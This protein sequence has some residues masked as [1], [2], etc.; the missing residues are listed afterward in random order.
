MTTVNDIQH[1]G[2]HYRSDYQHWDLVL[3]MNVPYLE[4]CATKYICRHRKKNGGQDL[5]KASHYMEK[6][7]ERFQ[8]NLLERTRVTS[9]LAPY[10]HIPGCMNLIAYKKDKFILFRSKN[11]LTAF[12]EDLT[13]RILTWRSEDDLSRII[14]LAR[15]GAKDLLNQDLLNQR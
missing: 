12:E 11:R 9:W 15:Q 3:D 13:W 14:L 6:R 8:S 5:L 1:G 7:L 2:D 10:A 4:G